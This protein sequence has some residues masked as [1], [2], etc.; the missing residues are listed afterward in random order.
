MHFSEILC[1]FLLIHNSFSHNL[2]TILAINI[3]GDFSF[4]I[5]F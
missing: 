4:E 2:Q 3:V 1:F 5:L